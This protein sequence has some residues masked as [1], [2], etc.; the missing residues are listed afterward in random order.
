MP[1][2]EWWRPALTTVRIP[3]YEIGQEAAH[4]LLEQIDHGADRLAKQILMP[5]SLTIRASTG[6]CPC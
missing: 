4:L 6:R 5:A 2:V 1:F 3:Q